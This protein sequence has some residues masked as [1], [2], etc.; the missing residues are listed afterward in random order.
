MKILI[1]ILFLG[2]FCFSSCSKSQTDIKGDIFLASND[3]QP[4]RFPAMQI[5]FIKKEKF[6]KSG[7]D[8]IAMTD[9]DYFATTDADG[10]FSVRLPKG[11]Y[12]AAADFKREKSS[13]YRTFYEH[14]YWRVPFTTETKNISLNNSNMQF[15]MTTEN[16]LR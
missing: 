14:Y 12:I 15:K 2:L 11:E 1:F 7:S 13:E 5:K 8:E 6:N 16:R 10:K 3:E 4:N 9:V